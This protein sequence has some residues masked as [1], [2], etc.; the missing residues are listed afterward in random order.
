MRVIVELVI[1][2]DPKAYNQEYATDYKVGEIKERIK[3]DA[4]DATTMTFSHI[5]HAVTSVMLRNP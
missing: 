5:D 3:W 2:V 1:E 4:Y